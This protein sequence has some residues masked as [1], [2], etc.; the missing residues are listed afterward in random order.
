MQ[1]LQ[2]IWKQGGF[3]GD[4]T[5]EFLG[6]VRGGFG[7]FFFF[8]APFAGFC[9][10]SFCILTAFLFHQGGA[11]AAAQY[12][13]GIHFMKNLAMAGGLFFLMLH[14]AGR[15]SLDHAIEK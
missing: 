14:G 11:D 7:F 4:F 5:I 9:P 3:K 13:N 15:I 12:N 2:E 6:V 1:Q 8:P 10:W